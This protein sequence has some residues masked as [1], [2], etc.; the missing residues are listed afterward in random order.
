[1]KDKNTEYRI[2]WGP[3]EVKRILGEDEIQGI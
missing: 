3:F 2:N 1:M